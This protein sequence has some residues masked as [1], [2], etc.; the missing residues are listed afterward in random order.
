MLAQS[1][2]FLPCWNAATSCHRRATSFPTLRCRERRRRNKFLDIAATATMATQ[3]GSVQV[4][5][6]SPEMVAPYSDSEPRRLILLRHAQSS[7]DNR[8]L[9]DYDRP[10]SQSGKLD[11]AKVSH[12]LRKL[13]WIPGLI[14]C[15]DAARTRETL[16]IMQEQ[17]REFL[18]AEV[19]FL[20]SFYFV[21]AMDGQTS[22]HLRQA[23]CKYSA[24]N[25][26]TV[27]CMGHNK[28]WEEAASMFSGALIELKTC[29][30][31]LLEATG[32][33]W[34][35]AFSLAGFG[36]WK[37]HGIVKPGTAI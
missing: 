34:K 16:K 15:S 3:S 32:K 7:W 31:A 14:L 35:E 24:D 29:N 1:L 20:S 33:S 19:H 12:E 30:A 21:A 25:V 17:V 22:E 9:K 11:A 4:Q 10:L 5:P 8:S 28:G 2:Q 6:G 26:L 37:L 18:E 23:I 27:M 13:G 36:G